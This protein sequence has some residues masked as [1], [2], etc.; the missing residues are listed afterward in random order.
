MM[1]K[2]FVPR[3]AKRGGLVTVVTVDRATGTVLTSAYANEEAWKLTLATGMAY[4]FSTSRD[5]VAMKGE[6]SGNIQHVVDVLVDCDG[7]A[8]VY[9]V[10]QVGPGACHTNAFSCFFRSCIG[11]R[12][13]MDAPLQGEKERLEVREVDVADAILSAVWQ[14]NILPSCDDGNLR[15]V[16]PTGSLGPRTR[17]LLKQVGYLLFEPDR[18]GYCGTSGGVDFFQRDRRMVPLQVANTFD[19]GLTG[20]DLVLASGVEGLRSIV[21]LCFSR[22]SNFPTR[23]VL[24]SDKEEIPS[25]GCI[26]V[27]C[28]YPILADKLLKERGLTCQFKTIAIEGNEEQAIDDGLCG[29]VLVVTETGGSLER[30]K[31]NILLDDL[32]VSTP[33]IIAK[34]DLP[35]AKEVALQQLCTAL[36][37]AL[38]A[39]ERVMV[40]AN[41]SADALRSIVLPASD[42]PTVTPLG[43]G[44]MVAVEVCVSCVDIAK[45][46]FV[47]RNADATA[48]VLQDLNGF[49]K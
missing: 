37:A 44:G 36:Q 29:F 7:D 27:G 12:Q 17:S 43:S 8:L 3:F 25:S 41:I 28:E 31:L 21:D 10:D 14:N 15:F 1:T 9:I 35:E 26:N 22:K 11:A 42:K 13:I 33:Q 39:D 4:Y 34:P 38:A 32:L 46:L 48:I 49:L 40:K 2:T 47:L 20:K 6:D 45:T 30:A 16:L 24:V 19:A 23:W 18:R 5:R